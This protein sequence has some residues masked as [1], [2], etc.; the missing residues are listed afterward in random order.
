MQA[1]EPRAYPQLR[2]LDL[3]DILDGTF[4]LYR[5]NFVTLLGIVAVAQVPLAILRT[6]LAVLAGTG[7]AEQL[8]NSGGGLPPG[9]PGANWF[10]VY[11]AYAN[12]PAAAILGLIETYIVQVLIIAALVYAAS[13][14]YLNLPVT[15][16]ESYRYGVKK[17]VP[18]IV[19]IILLSI[20]SALLVALPFGCMLA[21]FFL[22]IFGIGA[23]AAGGSD[24][25]GAF[26]ALGVV[27]GVVGLLLFAAFLVAL[28]LI[29]T[30]LAFYP[31]TVVV[32]GQG[33]IEC[34]TRS[35]KLVGGQMWRAVGIYLVISLLGAVLFGIIL[36]MFV[37]LGLLLGVT[38]DN[39]IDSYALI[40]TF[41]E[42]IRLLTSMLVQPFTLIGLTLLYYDLRVRKE[43]LDMELQT[44]SA[45]AT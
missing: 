16:A 36:L 19:A 32:E 15:I 29:G 44:A 8:L 1:S 39:P 20:G 9:V 45:G 11:L 4:R 33:P 41:F 30:R 42:L 7:S 26:A 40:V 14:R 12:A 5:S 18:L 6:L 31:Q 38:L 3:G 43:G 2:P 13:R 28:L 37:T 10:A 25:G 27:G 21:V 35:W 34:L 24:A 17:I 23:G 22:F